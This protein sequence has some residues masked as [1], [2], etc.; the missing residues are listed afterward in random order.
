[1]AFHF[2]AKVRT[3]LVNNKG[4]SI[5]LVGKGNGYFNLPKTHLQYN[6]LYSL[7][8]AAAANKDTLLIRTTETREVVSNDPKSISYMAVTW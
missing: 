1:M 4:C 8:L 7:A 6:A 2:K 3:I 5:R